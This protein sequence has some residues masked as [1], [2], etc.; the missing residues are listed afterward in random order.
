MATSYLVPMAVVRHEI[1]SVRGSRFLA[2]LAPVDSPEAAQTF[3]RT[4]EEAERSASHHVWAWRLAPDGARYRS[5]DA[6]EPGGSAGRPVLAQIERHA[7]V[8]V[9]VVVSRWF[10]GTKLGVGG[11]ARA[12]GAAAGAV[13]DRAEIRRVERVRRAI[14]AFPY[15]VSK[16]VEALLASWRIEP[17]EGRYEDNVRLVLDVPEAGWDRFKQDLA[18]GTAGRAAVLAVD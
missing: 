18:N 10:G 3:I 13:L 14:V 11:L 1:E 15:A 17:V 2:V 6:G 5:H 9:V 12:Y 7:C 16:A 8:D 4:I